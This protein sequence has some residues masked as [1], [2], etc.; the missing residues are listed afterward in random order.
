MMVG[1]AVC[2]AALWC[3]LLLTCATGA[4]EAA[5]RPVTLSAPDGVTLSG[6]LYEAAS[7]P[8]PAVVLVHMLGRSRADWDELATTLASA[9]VTALAIDVRGHGASGG[10]A[11]PLTDA[12][13]DVRA[14][15]QWLSQ[16][17]GVRP[18]ALGLV[19]ASMGANLAV[20]AALDAPLARV[21]ATVSLTLDYQGL[22]VSADAFRTL[23]GR[24][25]WMAA[26]RDDPYAARTIAELTNEG[27]PAAEQVLS[28]EPAHGSLLLRA[29]PE[30]VRALVDWLRVRL[31]S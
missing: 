16:R 13:Q 27:M 12:V 22:R 28:A 21:V 5:G 6:E 14:A 7:T 4:V 18:D 25:V 20:L 29:D 26:S 2:R 23:A 31:L 1:A 17:P 30:V 10:S 11:R 15:L 8:A 19:G 24:A 9:G 3:G